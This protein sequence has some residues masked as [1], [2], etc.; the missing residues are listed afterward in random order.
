MEMSDFSLAFSFFDHGINFL[1]KRHWQE[2]YDLSLQLFEGACKCALVNSDSLSLKLVSDQIL[3]FAT[4]FEDKL[5]T[6]FYNVTALAYASKLPESV[7]M[8]ISVLSQLGIELPVLSEAEITT[9]V[10]QTKLLLQG[11]T[12]QEL[13][14]YK[15]M[16]DPSMIMAM[17]FLA[18]LITAL[19]Y[20]MP[21]GIPIITLKMIQLS[22]NHGMSPV[23]PIGLVYFGHHVASCGDISKGCHYLNIA[24]KLQNRIGSKDFAGEVICSSSQLFGF[25]KPLQIIVDHH[26][27][28][29]NIAMAAGDVQ[30]AMLNLMFYCGVGFWC[31]TKLTICKK[32]F[33]QS[34]R[35]MDQHGHFNLLSH[36]IQ[37]EE[38]IEKLV[39]KADDQEGSLLSNDT[40]AKMEE[41]LKNTHHAGSISFTFQE[42]Y[43]HFMFREYDD[44]KLS[45]EKFFTVYNVN[46]R[47]YIFL[48]TIVHRTFYGGLVAFWIHRQ[49]KDPVWFKRGQAAKVAVKKCAE[50]SHHNFQHKLYLLEAE[51]AFCNNNN[52]SAESLYEKSVSTA[53]DHR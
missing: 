7:D 5:N 27:E 3:C 32:R 15:L 26:Y 38:N 1:R 17:K 29:Y 22:I 23:S 21:A 13:I 4:R 9:C 51:E 16:I 48:L 53:R 25:F 45:A 31:G 35:L 20:T 52:E 10:E 42:M 41:I 40:A 14:D 39:G 24:R 46:S 8:A 34:R 30:D 47:N 49:T 43:I 11:L 2:Q 18:R 6:L 37:L 36:L 12:D 50:S 44:M 28:G 33:A 19:Y